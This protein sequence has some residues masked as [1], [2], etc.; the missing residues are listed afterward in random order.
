MRYNYEFKLE[1]VEMYKDGKYPETPEG[2]TKESFRGKIRMWVRQAEQL[3]NE[4]L[5]HKSKN[6]KYSDGEKVELIQEMINGKSAKEI[7]VR[8]GIDHS[9]L[10]RWVKKYRMEGYEGLATKKRGR[11]AKE[12][13]M[14][15]KKVESAG[16]TEAEREELVR[17]RARNEYLEAEIAALKKEQAL[18][19][20]KWDE[21]LKAKKQRSSKNSKKKDTD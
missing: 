15:K 18:R 10:R 6:R 9:V 16:L 4:S 8:T 5:R 13:P 19:Y 20:A 2:I 1:C 17:I 11:P 7:A 14:A 3:G 12:K 21:E